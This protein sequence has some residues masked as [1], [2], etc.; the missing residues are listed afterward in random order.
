MRR[1][2]HRHGVG[3]ARRALLRGK[4]G[5]KVRVLLLRSADLLAVI[6]L[7]ALF[8]ADG[9]QHDS[10]HVGIFVHDLRFGQDRLRRH[11]VDAAKLPR[12]VKSSRTGV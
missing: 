12:L 11:L 1:H 9:P 8:R 7:V 10:G 5:A 4:N 2:G 3:A 6:K